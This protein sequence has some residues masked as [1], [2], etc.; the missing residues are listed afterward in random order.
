MWQYF[1]SPKT[2]T[3]RWQWSRSLNSDDWFILDNHAIISQQRISSATLM[4]LG[5]ILVFYPIVTLWHNTS[6]SVTLK[7]WDIDLT[8]TTASPSKRKMAASRTH[9]P[10]MKA[11][12]KAQLTNKA[13]YSDSYTPVGRTRAILYSMLDILPNK[14]VFTI[15]SDV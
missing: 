12:D 5:D 10:Q 13:T 2:M 1:N 15:K 6:N 9:L 8:D 4:V 11:I 3:V 7:L 14:P